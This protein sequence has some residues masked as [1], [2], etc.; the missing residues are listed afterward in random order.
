M[1]LLLMG[2]RGSGKTTL[3]PLIAKQLSRPW[4]DLDIET[5][6]ELC[7]SGKPAQTVT[8]AWQT[9][10]EPAFRAAET[11]ALVRVLKSD[12]QVIAL[13]GGTPTAP[14]AADLLRAARSNGCTRIVYLRASAATLRDRL[15]A[16]D[17]GTRPSLT[18]A[19][20]VDEIETVL[21]ARDPLYQSLADRVIEIEAGSQQQIAATIATQG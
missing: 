18:G 8:E 5:L 11:K 6:A 10:G 4:L 3:A 12:N 2:L 1:N 16:T 20:P 19:N 15:I 9:Y 7:A 21:A 13:G 14:G 17:T